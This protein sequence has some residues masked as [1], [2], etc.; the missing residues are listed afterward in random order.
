MNIYELSLTKITKEIEIEY[1]ASMASNQCFFK[2]IHLE[3]DKIALMYYFSKDFLKLNIGYLEN[4]A[5]FISII[6]YNV[7]IDFDKDNRLNDFIE[8]RK[9]KLAYIGK[10]DDTIFS[11]VLFDIYN[12]FKNMKV[13]LFQFD[14]EE[15]KI[16]TEFES[17]LYNDYLAISSTVHNI[18][19]F[20]YLVM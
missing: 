13:R 10:S 9:N 19:Y 12:D 2:G 17:F 8:I 14:L 15:H 20:S 7:E 6:V 1:I 18:Q 5:N 11:I 16:E 3:E 4:N